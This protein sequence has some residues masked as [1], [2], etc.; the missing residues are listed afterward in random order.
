MKAK[1]IICVVTVALLC[2][3]VNGELITD[4][5][6][7][8]KVRLN[9]PPK[10]ALFSLHDVRLL[11]G[12]FKQAQDIAVKYLLSLDSD[13]LLARYRME[14]GLEPKAQPYGGW[15]A[16]GIAGHSLGH[17]LSGCA[18][19]YASTGDKR[20]LDRVNYIVDQLAECQ[21]AIGTGYVAGIPNGK[22][23]YAEVAAGNIRSSGFDLNGSWVPNYNL[24]KLFAGLRDA[25]RLCTN[26]TALEVAKKLADWFD[27]VHANLTE[28]QMQRVLAC[29][30]GGL[31]ETFADLYAD[32]GNERY[33]KLARRIYHKA[34]L[35]PLARGED[36]LP[37]KHANTQ[38]PKLIGLA[39]LY[40]LTGNET[41]R[42]AA[43][44]FWER[45]VYHH[46]YVTG[47][48]SDRE[49]FG[50]PDRLNNRLS[51]NTAE[52]C[53]VYNML[54]LTR[55]VFG[56]NPSAAVADFY[57]RALL[58]HIRATQHPDGRVMYYLSLQPGHYK[59]YQTHTNSFTC[60]VGTGMENHVRY[61]E[62]IYFHDKD[63]LCVNLFIA[64][65]LNW[66]ARGVKVRQDTAWPESDT[67]TLTFSCKSPQEFTLRIRHPHWAEKLVVKVNGRQL[68]QQTKPSSYFELRRR[69]RTGDKV[70]VSF[71]MHL[72]TESMPDNTNRIAIFYGPTVLASD[73]GPVPDAEAG[74]PGYVPVMLTEGRPVTNWIKQ[75][76][77][78]PLKFRTVGVGKPRDV[79]LVPLWQLHD[80][81][82]TVYLDLFSKD[83][84]AQR[85][86]E[87]RAEEQR[88]LELVA[89]TTDIL[90]IGEMQPERDHNLQGENTSVG[91]FA[92]RKWRHATDGGWFSFEMK[93]PQDAPAELVCTYWGGDSGNRVF[94][95]L[96]DGEKIATQRLRGNRQNR[97]YD[98]TYP[99]PENLTRG[100]QKVTVKF[101]AHPDATAG[102]VFG[103]RMVKGAPGTQTQ[104]E[105]NPTPGG[106][107]ISTGNN[108]LQNP[109]FE[110]VE[111]DRPRA[112]RQE[113]WQGEGTF[114]VA[115]IG[116]TGNRSVMISSAEGADIAWA[117]TV[118]VEPNA[119]YRLTGWIKTENVIATSGMGA[120][121]NVHGL[122]GAV[123]EA[124]TGT[125]DW[126]RVQVE[127][128][129]E[130]LTSIQVNCLF[131]GW[132]LATGKAWYDDVRLE[133]VS[134]R[135]QSTNSAP[136]RIV[137]DA[138]KTME[139]IPLYIY[140]QFIE[141]LGRC[142]YGGIWAEMLEDRKFYYPITADYR[143]YRGLTDQP[144]PIIGASPWQIIG[145]ADSVTMNTNQPFVGKHTPQIR[146]GAGIRQLDLGVTQGKKYTGYAWLKSAD[147][148][149]ASVEIALVWGDSQADRQIAKI[150]QI[151]REYRK[152]TFEFVA[153]ATTDKAAF[154]LRVISGTA[155]VGTLSLMP[156]DNIE[157]MRADTLALL[158]ELNAPIY[159]WPG[160]NFVS[161][162][163]WHDGIGERDR[164]PPRK[165]P[166]WTGVEPNDFGLHEYIRF[167]RLLNAE[168]MITVNTG[169]G[170]AHS[171][172]A[173]LE[174]CNGPT[175]TFWGWRRATNGAPEPFNVKHWCIG[176]EMWGSWQ[177][178]H[179]RLE[180][181][182]L[183]HNWV[184]EKMREIDPRILCYA[185]GDAGPWS[186]GLLQNCADYMDYI[187]EHFYCQERR[188]LPAHVRQVPDNIRR[189]AEFHRNVRRELAALKDKD[190]RIAMTEWNY[191]YGPHVFG[192]LGTRYFLKDA[193]GIAAGLHEYARNTDII[194]S[195]FYAQTVN[196]IGCIKTSRR[197]AAFE[198]TGL[199][200]KL[201]RHHFGRLPVATQTTGTIDAQAAWTSDRKTLTIGIVNPSL[202]EAKV[203]LSLQGAK[204]TGRG[205]RWQIAGT[206]PMAYNDP[207]LPPGI[208]IV[209]QTVSGLSNT[210]T[211]APCSVTLFSLEA[212]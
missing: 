150:E 45:V 177:L 21:R 154:E 106:A 193:L 203:E 70:E 85:E 61:A 35:E 152:F 139:P 68:T 185:S 205:K 198:T 94:D 72:R 99:I 10:A 108:L 192:E 132:G 62:A 80:R 11:D 30:H 7:P 113:Q 169:F 121:F 137:I 168:P 194:A 134:K 178:G 182:V 148:G 208:V 175:N 161:G 126:T 105:P 181:Y 107:S 31:N 16:Q 170:D 206:D 109:S 123:T 190:I 130:D 83:E 204:L 23:V 54:K 118:D 18:L 176:N 66:R 74:K 55:H 189:K 91:E 95:I 9:V 110:D 122:D 65:E 38:I 111:G 57:E 142:I 36:I 49:Y 119:R 24:H 41:D 3:V 211:V 103:V 147:A 153:G 64:S 19:A 191:W 197:N 202:Q 8:P 158:K 212:E 79:E 146:A 60:C 58:N 40:E 50:P 159:R 210:L 140:G 17:Y 195:A 87:I 187:A 88:Q 163:D 97:F 44:F 120:L 90:H 26:K 144:F 5:Q 42:S 63:G 32:T 138:A 86:A 112:W 46:S 207:D 4:N 67:A 186:R 151:G 96:V 115:N 84:W 124:V 174:Y 6:P 200:L 116:R 143:P 29:E 89:R 92:G 82:Y 73:L 133:L 129:T 47:S 125:K 33:L 183:K 102:G 34:I 78:L 15:E 75:V 12:P 128:D 14:A 37:G 173:L 136:S 48:H 77:K 27:S 127:F 171:A 162:Y 104:Q 165:N 199:V 43:N 13:R 51:P 131:G 2:T 53:N 166:A 114:A 71:P 179:M 93:V 100:K 172:A 149:V 156:A 160:G 164:R 157:G 1:L 155:L 81:R 145:R 135:P 201:Y 76:S 180:H 141:H 22:R 56:W 98:V 184:V 167:C 101:Q 196:V 117:T 188:S 52:T 59:E 209:E 28:E 25:Y 69:W 20:F 39:T